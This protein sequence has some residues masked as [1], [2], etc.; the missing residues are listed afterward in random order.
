MREGLTNGLC[1]QSRALNQQDHD[2]LPNMTALRT[3]RAFK[4]GI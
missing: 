2:A 1:C 3:C 4:Q